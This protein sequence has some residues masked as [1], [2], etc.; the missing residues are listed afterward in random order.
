M[1]RSV[2]KGPFYDASLKKQK[3]NRWRIWSR[4]SVILPEFVGCY[5]QIYNGKGFVGSKITEDM[6]GH[7]F[8]EFAST[9]KISKTEIKPKKKVR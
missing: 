2:W 6:I 8:G 3:R 7:K 4:R 5:A 1:T 9:R